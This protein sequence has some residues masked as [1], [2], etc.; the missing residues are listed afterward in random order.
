MVHDSQLT[1]PKTYTSFSMKSIP[2]EGLAKSV[3]PLME[4]VE[5]AFSHLAGFQPDFV[6]MYRRLPFNAFYAANMSKE[7]KEVQDKLSTSVAAH[8]KLKSDN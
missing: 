6:E 2:P 5:S 4:L 8:D 7:V 3:T 1:D